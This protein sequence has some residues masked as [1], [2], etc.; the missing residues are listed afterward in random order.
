MMGSVDAIMF[1]AT[2]DCSGRA[3]FG[4]WFLLRHEETI[5]RPHH[6]HIYLK[7]SVMQ[8]GRGIHT[9]AKPHRMRND[10]FRFKAAAPMAAPLAC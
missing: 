3:G 2:P 4:G 9:I 5:E 6:R 7:S 1:E 8:E 10:I